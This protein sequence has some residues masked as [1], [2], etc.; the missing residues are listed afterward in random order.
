MKC[1]F[2]YYVKYLTKCFLDIIYF[3]E[4]KCLICSCDLDYEYYVCKSCSNKLKICK[5]YKTIDVEEKRIEIYSALY[6]S[7]AAKELI[8]KLKYKSCFKA[9]DLLAYFMIELLKERKLDYDIITFVPLSCN[10]KKKR[11]Y[12]QSEYLAIIIGNYFKKP[13]K[14]L[15]YKVKDTKDQIGLSSDERWLNLKESF[16]VKKGKLENKKILIVDDVITTGA[17]SYFCS[18]ELIKNKVSKIFILTAA[19]SKI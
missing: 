17:T 10:T 19:K 4:E 11:G 7:S 15:I 12:N 3:K 13:V 18:L 1:K 9:G 8:L 6:Y 2:F 16:K 14:K 5:D